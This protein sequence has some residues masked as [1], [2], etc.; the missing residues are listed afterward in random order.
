MKRG[1][2]RLE[3]TEVGCVEEGKNTSCM[4][5]HGPQASLPPGMCSSWN[6]EPPGPAQVSGWDSSV[7][8]GTS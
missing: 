8:L 2:T 6:S 4:G 7:P 1:E 3:G 5:H